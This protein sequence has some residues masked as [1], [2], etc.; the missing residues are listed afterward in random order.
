MIHPEPVLP[1][2]SGTHPRASTPAEV[3]NRL[4]AYRDLL[5]R[6]HALACSRADAV[7]R[8]TFLIAG[9]PLRL[10]IAGQTLADLTLPAFAH[11]PEIEAT[12]VEG[13]FLLW[14]E[15]ATHTPLPPRP[16][17]EPPRTPGVTIALPPGGEGYR[18]SQSLELDTFFLMERATGLVLLAAKDAR[19]LPF[20]QRASPL[21]LPLHWWASAHKLRAVHAGSVATAAGAALIAG[22]SGA[23]KSTTSLLCTLAGMQYL[24]DDYCLVRPGPAPESFCL[25]NNAKLHRD[26][27]AR[28]PALAS[29]AVQPPPHSPDKPVVFLHQHFP[30]RVRLSAPV[31]AIVLPVVTGR[32][33]TVA[34]RLAPAAAIR[35]LASSSIAQLPQ[36]DAGLF[37]DLA[38]LARR[39]PCHR[40]ELGT[41]L[42]DIAPCVRSLIDHAP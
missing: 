34:V 17:T 19:L 8:R 27:F 15:A 29:L 10:V 33:E 42:E 24:S 26:H 9:L 3:A 1:P 37:L 12:H 13:E 36:D 2:N 31:R 32:A 41:R 20:Y 30:E 39:V 4:H 38:G 28:F 25:F 23:G 7:I 35:S 5:A 16:W 11:L 22:P 40:L 21:L 6:T 18:Y 14:D